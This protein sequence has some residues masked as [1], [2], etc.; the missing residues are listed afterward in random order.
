[1]RSASTAVLYFANENIA[2]SNEKFK[3]SVTHFIV[4]F[5]LSFLSAFLLKVEFAAEIN[6]NIYKCVDLT[7]SMSNFGFLSLINILC[8]PVGFMESCCTFLDDVHASGRHVDDMH[9][10]GW[11]T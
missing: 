8:Y 10:S 7:D 11:H 5:F 6:I 4:R 9:V 3:W 1:M 2:K